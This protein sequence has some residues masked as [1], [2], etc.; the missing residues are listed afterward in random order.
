M[1]EQ[2]TFQHRL[3]HVAVRAVVGVVRRLPL[4]AVLAVGSLLGRAF[5]VF[6][7]AHRR[8]AMS[9]LVAA[10]PLR[11]RA[12][13]RAIARGMFSHFGRLL[14]VLLKF[15]TMKPERMLAQVEFEGEE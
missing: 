2:P 6:D 11:S 8:L 10:F 14:M 12:E 4:R 7:R 3:E 9:N 5:Y 13:C 1:V 15:S